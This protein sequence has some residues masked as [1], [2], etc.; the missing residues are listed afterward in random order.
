MVLHTRRL[1][2]ALALAVSLT[3]GLVT[4]SRVDAAPDADPDAAPS[5]TPTTLPSED[6]APEPPSPNPS[7]NPSTNPAPSPASVP[8][9][10]TATRVETTA[11]GDLDP[12]EIPVS[13]ALSTSQAVIT[14]ILYNP[15]A[16]Y[17]SRGEWFE[18]RNTGSTP[19]DLSGWTFG[20]EIYDI[21][22]I[23]A[24]S[25][26]PGAHAVLA[27]FGDPAR[28]GGV[29]A[30][31]V[32]GDSVL[33]YNVGDQLI[34]RDQLGA[35]VDEVDYGVE[36]FDPANGRSLSLGDPTA[37][38]ASGS[39]WCLATTP[40]AAGDRG[41]PGR[42]N[43]C[44]R[45]AAK[46][47]ITEIM[48]NPSATSDATGE[49]FELRNDGA[50]TVD[51]AGFRV[52]DDDG[53]SFTIS[54]STV[55]P[56]G[57]F[58]VLGTNADTAVNGGVDLDV[59]YGSQMRLHNTFDE[60]IIL[61]AAGVQVD[62]VRWD[63]G[64][65]FPNPNGASMNLAGSPSPGIDNSIGSN[66]CTS[67]RR[68][69]AGDA[70]SPGT[71]GTCAPV[72]VPDVVI[73][74]VMFDPQ[75]TATERSGE[76]FELTNTGTEPAV[77]DGFTL[78][79]YSTAHVVSSLSIAP[80]GRAVLAA[81]GSPLD[82]GGVRADYVYGASLPL[83]NTSSTLELV[84][85]D[86]TLVDRVKWSGEL[87]FP[88]EPGHS[89]ELNQPGANG[90]LGANWCSTI[91]RYGDG[92]F[93]TP[94]LTG[95][96]AA[97]PAPLP[98]KIS[99]VMKNPAAVSDTVG[100]W[101]EVFNP[102]ADPVDLRGWSV[103]D[104]GSEY[105]VITSSVVVPANGYAV[106]GRSSNFALNGGVEVATATGD[107]MVLINSDDELVLS[108][109]YGQVVDRLAWNASS[110]EPRPN[111]GSIAR[112][113]SSM[114]ALAASDDVSEWCAGDVQYGAGDRGTP[115]A[116]N[117]CVKAPDHAIVINEVHRD[118]QA[119][120]DARG[121]WLELHNT[122]DAAID[123]SGW[124]LRDDDVDSFVFD[125]T[126][127]VVIAAGGYLVAA[128]NTADLNGG[129]PVDIT[130]GTEIIH[131]NTA[132]EI[133][134]LDRDLAVVDRVAWTAENGFPKVPGATMALRSPT[135]DNAVGANW[136]ASVTSQ[137]NAD[138]G[139]PGT[140]NLCEIPVEPD[141]LLPTTITHSI[142]ATGPAA[143]QGAVDLRGSRII[144]GDPVRANA[145]FRVS[146]STIQFDGAVSYGGN[147][148]VGWGSIFTDGLIA[149]AS[150]QTVPFGWRIEDFAPGGAR[151]V[152]AG[153]AYV[154]HS[155]NL[156]INGPSANLDAGV[157]FVEG[158]VRINAANTLLNGV[159]IVATG[160]ITINSSNVALTPFAADHPALMSGFDACTTA[161][162]TINASTITTHG[163]LWAPQARVKLAASLI[164]SSS[165]AVVGS[166]VDMAGSSITLNRRIAFVRITAMCKGTG[167]DAGRYLFRVRHEGNS[168]G[169]FDYELRVGA[170]VLHAG[171]IAAG[172]TQ[173]QW[174]ADGSQGVKVIAVGDW[175]NEY[176]GTASSN[177]KK[178]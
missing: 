59:D 137:G 53:E 110:L 164:S 125:P 15:E 98:L 116:E 18:I 91:E 46:L 121:E 70:G 13:S 131:Y 93:G 81:E 32:Y 174:L 136:C 31:Y 103:S 170:T 111:G 168:I 20:D 154:V 9:L 65:T 37:D 24:L 153:A 60:L 104:D 39:N 64:R 30:D 123:I 14:E 79:T 138:F 21:H 128:R 113:T 45:S 155:G 56:A 176:S 162:I 55:V 89:I 22:T 129:V 35:T 40:M 141:P 80:G 148:Q 135:L 140:A 52:Q 17:D 28:N 161:G 78:R 29:T 54:G 112:S 156:I 63:D 160:S 12:T 48:N 96:C 165:G 114:L 7:T 95:A 69:A 94:G 83:Y 67:T 119:V 145:D 27:R 77:L 105:H 90:L 50:A 99:E 71:A 159:T 178:C 133:M 42:A 92:D 19:L 107:R 88:N 171:Q 122:G 144:V 16:V 41:T 4:G 38:N 151:A 23:S 97:V 108:D 11:T 167:A 10:A 150:P 100:E 109:R 2:L 44:G 143:C 87:G 149:D 61:D 175:A 166:S 147:S 101:F 72:I 152:A 82:N 169:V 117:S 58:V 34:L 76:W 57:A 3:A 25:I 49:W 84:A 118:P 73:T 142:F 134:L 132:D 5:T 177:G 102:T 172:E 85:P 163:T 124:T 139:T 43:Q 173:F 26:A 106:I 157:H 8:P 130:Y 62:A 126:T 68:W 33:L 120:P 127:P 66:W 36:G 51:L 115:G 74:E 1:N 47:T 75:R 146:G 158:D 6:P 86:A